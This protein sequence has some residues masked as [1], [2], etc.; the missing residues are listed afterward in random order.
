M[1]CRK[2]VLSNRDSIQERE[3]ESDFALVLK[4]QVMGIVVVNQ[5]TF[6]STLHVAPNPY[7]RA[8]KPGYS[9]ALA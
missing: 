2:L 9:G 7:P 8:S 4:D 3:F 1:L 6:W 5:V